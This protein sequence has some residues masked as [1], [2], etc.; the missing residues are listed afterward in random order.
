MPWAY[1]RW[2]QAQTYARYRFHFGANNRFYEDGIHTM[3][4]L[5]PWSYH[6]LVFIRIV[7]F[8]VLCRDGGLVMISMFGEACVSLRSYFVCIFS[9]RG[10][11]QGY[12]HLPGKKGR[13]VISADTVIWIELWLEFLI[14]TLGWMP[15]DDWG[16]TPQSQGDAFEIVGSVE[17][18]KALCRTLY[19]A[20][21]SNMFGWIYRWFKKKLYCMA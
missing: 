11:V 16:N 4:S 17:V 6:F 5:L 10:H 3:I 1:P 14:V 15:Q 9:A 20:T 2:S 8:L 7:G 12:L 19:L 13:N 18:D 21:A